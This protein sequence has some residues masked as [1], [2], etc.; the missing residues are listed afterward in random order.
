MDDETGIPE[1]EIGMD[2]DGRIIV[3]MPF[4]NNYGYWTDNNLLLADFKGHFETIEIS[5]DSF[6]NHWSLF[7]K[8][9]DFETEL[10]EFKIQSTGT[11]GEHKYLRQKL[12]ITD[13][14]EK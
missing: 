9:T 3:K 1:R 11:N 8:T 2:K 10:T 6:E 12:S 13:R 5:R 4:K 7:G 14:I